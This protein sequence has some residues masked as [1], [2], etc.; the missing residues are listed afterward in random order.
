[1]VAQVSLDDERYQAGNLTD[2]LF[3][4]SLE[5]LR[6]IKGI[7]EASVCLTLPYERGL[8][9]G[10][11]RMD[12]PVIDEQ[13]QITSLNYV[14]PG[15]FETMRIPVLRGRSIGINDHENSENI[16]LVNQ[17]FVKMYLADHEVI[18]T[19][20]HR[21][22]SGILDTYNIMT[23]DTD[24]VALN[25]VRK[26]AIDL[27]MLCPFSYESVFYSRPE[28]KSTFYQRITDGR[29]PDWLKKVELPSDL[30]PSFTLFEVIE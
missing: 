21:N 27:I 20:Y 9:L 18:G 11:R 5:Q 29:I 16:I 30:S 6:S 19:P 1:M 28:Q 26:R 24:E 23:A 22:S 8:N 3:D 4:R 12:G 10:F 14:T 2:Q 13:G 7:E 15:Y 25:L 17:A